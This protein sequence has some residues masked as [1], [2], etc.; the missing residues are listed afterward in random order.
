MNGGNAKARDLVRCPECGLVYVSRR[1]PDHL[2]YHGRYLRAVAS[3]NYRPMF[4]RERR[5]ATRAAWRVIDAENSSVE[6]KA[7]AAETV[8]KCFFDRSLEM[9]IESNW[10]LVHPPFPKYAGMFLRANP[11]A[12]PSPVAGALKEKYGL[13]RGLPDGRNIWVPREWE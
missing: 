10:H 6:E 8:L 4:L 5:E 12:F 11:N 3:L 13:R 9:A 2:K 1:D 7:K